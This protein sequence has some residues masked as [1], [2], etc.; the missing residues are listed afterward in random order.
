MIKLYRKAI[1]GTWLKVKSGDNLQ[2]Y[3]IRPSNPNST[4]VLKSSQ[5][6]ETE[7]HGSCLFRTQDL[8]HY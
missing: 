3:W 7:C 2:E 5:V 1:G 8:T 6:I 4:Q